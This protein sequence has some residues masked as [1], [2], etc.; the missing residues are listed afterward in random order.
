MYQPN[1][2]KDTKMVSIEPLPLPE[3]PKKKGGRKKH[4]EEQKTQKRVAKGMHPE[5]DKVFLSK[6]RRVALEK[7]RL[8]KSLKA[9]YRHEKDEGRKEMLAVKI[10]ALANKPV[11]VPLA[12]KDLKEKIKYQ[13]PAY[14]EE[15]LE[16]YVLDHN[17]TLRN[18][19][20]PE[21]S[22]KM[23]QWS[24]SHEKQTI[25]SGKIQ[26]LETKMNAL[27]N[28]LSKIR[29]LSGEGTTADY[30]NPANI[31]Q[32]HFIQPHNPKITPHYGATDPSP[33]ASS[34]PFRGLIAKRR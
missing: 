12:N 18:T 19:D 27:D 6:N 5:K 31:S 20:Q 30:A 23:L 3:P 28:Y 15:G 2:A 11:A 21:Y 8:V 4:T 10:N 32:N 24:N 13:N 14:K 17:P 33:F 7:A 26:E 34:V 16:D 29:V 22:D 1:E 25:W 9:E